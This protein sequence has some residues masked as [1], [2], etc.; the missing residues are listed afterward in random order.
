MAH[1]V[2][3]L[4]NVAEDRGQGAVVPDRTGEHIGNGALF[5]GIDDAVVNSLGLDEFPHASAGAH[6]VDGI[7]MVVVPAGDGALGIDILSERGAEPGSLQIVHGQRVARE[8]RVDKAG[9]DEL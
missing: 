1:A 8:D 6:V 2:L 4:V 9:L 7:E 5:T 3:G